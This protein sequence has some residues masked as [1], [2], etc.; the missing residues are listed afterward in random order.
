MLNAAR[1]GE[2][3]FALRMASQADV[4]VFGNPQ[5]A[6]TLT[7]VETAKLKLNPQMNESEN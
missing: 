1:T 6:A 4:K 5:S 3:Y 7:L 2:E